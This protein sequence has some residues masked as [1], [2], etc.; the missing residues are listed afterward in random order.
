[1]CKEV[2]KYREKL[3]KLEQATQEL[4]KEI[5]GMQ[6][7]IKG[8]IACKKQEG[9]AESWVKELDDFE[10]ALEKIEIEMTE[11]NVK[12]CIPDY[13]LGGKSGVVAT[14]DFNVISIIK[15][16]KCIRNVV[17]AKETLSLPG[18][19]SSYHGYG[20]AKDLLRAISNFEDAFLC[21]ME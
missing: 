4:K 14:Y 17:F 9:N 21:Y 2:Q 13:F 5:F 16:L 10:L 1:M 8:V 18:E 7:K 15:M 6:C 19:K 11:E 20:L 12:F 3:G